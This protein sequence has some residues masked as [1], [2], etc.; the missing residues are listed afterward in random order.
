MI[1]LNSLFFFPLIFFLTFILPFMADSGRKTV[2]TTYIN[3]PRTRSAISA[4]DRWIRT[5]VTA[6]S[7]AAPPP[8][9]RGQGDHRSG[10]TAGV[11]LTSLYASPPPFSLISIIVIYAP[12]TNLIA[13]FILHYRHLRPFHQSHRISPLLIKSAASTS[14]R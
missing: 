11:G 2:K 13:F 10:L 14:S 6:S 8:P 12:S 5:R 3:L 7:R 4:Q 9:L 1:G